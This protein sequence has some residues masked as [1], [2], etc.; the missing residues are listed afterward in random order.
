MNEI[1]G[2]LYVCDLRN[3]GCLAKCVWFG[4]GDAYCPAMEQYVAT[5]SIISKNPRA[6]TTPSGCEAA[7]P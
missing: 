1:L 3:S 7:A 6:A 4:E 2:S 5:R